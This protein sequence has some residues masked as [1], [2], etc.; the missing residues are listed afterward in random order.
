MPLVTHDTP[1]E[2]ENMFVAYADNVSNY[3]HALHPEYSVTRICEWVRNYLVA[4][5]QLLKNRYDQVRHNGEDID[6]PRSKENTILPTV[7]VL[8][9]CDPEDLQQRHSYGNQTFIEDYDLTK[10]INEYRSKVISPFGS[11]YETTDKCS[12][13][14]K[15][16]V[17]V[18]KKLRKAEKKKMLQAK[19]DG[20][21]TA[22]VFHNN[23]QAT[24]KIMMNSL[25]GAMGSGFNFLSSIA[26]FNSV[27]SIARYCI[28]NSYAHAERFL[29]SNFYF[30]TEEQLLNFLVTCKLY[31][32]PSADVEKIV[33]QYQIYEPSCDD[34]YDFLIGSLHRYN[35]P[36][37]HPE[38]RKYIATCNLGERCFLFYMSNMKQLVFKNEDF[39]RPW[40]DDLFVDTHVDYTLP[41]APEDLFKLDGDLVVVLST[42]YNKLMPTNERGNS[43]SVYDLLEDKFKNPELAKRLVCI[44][45]YMQSRLDYIQPLFD[46]FMQHSVGIGYVAEHKYMFRDTVVTSDTDSIIFTTKSWVQWYN[47]MLKID[48]RAFNMNALTVYWLSKANANILFHLS[49]IFGALGDDMFIL[50]MKNEFMMPIEILTSLKKHYASIL[51]IQEGVFYSTPRLDIKGVNLRGSNFSKGTLNYVE[52]FIR[53]LINDIVETGKM[54]ARKY[55]LRV[56][57]FERMIY[58]TLQQG[59]AKFLTVDPVKSKEEY[60]DADRTIYFNYLFWEQVFGDKYGNIAVP[61][62][63]YILP[64]TNV[65][66]H[67]Y[68]YHLEQTSP[69]IAKRLDKFLQ[70]NPDKN[71]SRIPINPLT[72][73][74]PDELKLITNYKNI[75]SQNARP[76]YLILSSFGIGTGAPKKQNTLFSDIYGWVSKEDG[77]LAAEH[78][79]V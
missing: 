49:S 21:K 68:L 18:K 7:K 71:I 39:F 75:I 78:A 17:D 35:F 34:V 52:W 1:P 46:I 16:M 73:K 25:I 3:I 67:S 76:L 28:M 27:T 31:G 41:V 55:I 45:K 6:Q 30:R 57:Q 47:G 56:L 22:E 48:Q 59:D 50:N 37:D 23:N 58:N 26:N 24:I 5:Q 74:I 42:V 51:K 43:I 19:K 70:K 66:H 10:L 2:R 60:T 29:E 14:L 69:D 72:N 44:G 13:F 15:G 53:D 63:C 38:I 12:S 9:Y 20:D 36:S 11:F 54:N 62:K 79:A 64:L 77:E 8:K 65:R 32:P 40:I 33:K 61:T 4:H